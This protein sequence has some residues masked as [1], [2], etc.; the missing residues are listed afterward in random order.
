[1]A[2]QS[3]E[4]LDRA[5][6]KKVYKA[7]LN[8][9][10][11]AESRCL[12]KTD[13]TVVKTVNGKIPAEKL[14]MAVDDILDFARFYNFD[15]K[16][17]EA[18]ESGLTPPEK[19]NIAPA[20]GVP[21]EIVFDE[22]S[23]M[24]YALTTSGS[25]TTL[26]SV[27]DTSGSNWDLE[28]VSAG[29]QAGKLYLSSETEKLYRWVPAASGDGGT[30]LDI[31]SKSIYASGVD[32]DEVTTVALGN[33]PAGKTAEELK[34]MTIS[35]LL[36][37]ILFSDTEPTIAPL[38]DFSFALAQVSNYGG[39]SQKVWVG[40]A[41]PSSNSDFTLTYTQRASNYPTAPGGSTY[42]KLTGS[43][44]SRKIEVHKP[45]DNSGVYGQTLPTKFEDAG[46]YIYKGT[47]NYDDGDTL[48]T[49]RGALAAGDNPIPA[50]A[51]SKTTTI[52]VCYPMYTNG[53]NGSSYPANTNTI[54]LLSLIDMFDTAVAG[55]IVIK[56]AAEPGSV[57]SDASKRQQFFFPHG[58]TLAVE[59]KDLQGNWVTE[60]AEN[61]EIKQSQL[62]KYLVNGTWKDSLQSGETADFTQVFDQWVSKG[63]GNQGKRDI[64]FTI[65]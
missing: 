4:F 62:T 41:A 63:N 23:D 5:G 39:G 36:D 17:A 8:K 49:K 57:A 18:T 65:S 44:T 34:S 25:Q 38:Y 51:A 10:K 47:V 26:H 61:Y 3:Y 48:Y 27:W 43:E 55:K 1:M 6:T 7:L 30:M 19:N 50:G 53:S 42:P 9:V 60:S 56:F 35:E 11:S 28:S 14:P 45:T 2:N 33:L 40:S 21:F 46:Y 16:Y 37:A 32:S 52:K 13:G 24:F 31:T 64:R 29:P 22:S 59:G 15:E 12:S 58:K 54:N 20:S